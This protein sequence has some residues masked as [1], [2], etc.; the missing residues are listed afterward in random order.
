MPKGT[1][2]SLFEDNTLFCALLCTCLLKWAIP[3]MKKSNSACDLTITV[4]IGHSRVVQ[5]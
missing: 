5:K 1:F 3:F 4:N 2:A